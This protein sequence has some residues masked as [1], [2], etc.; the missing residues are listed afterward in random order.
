VTRELF[1]K[2]LKRLKEQYAK[3]HIGGGAPGQPVELRLTLALEY[4]REY[5]TFEHMSNDHQ[6]P[7]S[8]INE[9]VLWVEYALSCDEEFKLAELKEWFK[10]DEESDIE[11]IIV[12]VEEQPIERP[13]VEQEKSYSGKKTTHDEVPNRNQSKE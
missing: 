12:D 3:D 13:K 8:T 7:K 5:R 9:M 4:W 1:E 2:M 6:I 11:I 10:P